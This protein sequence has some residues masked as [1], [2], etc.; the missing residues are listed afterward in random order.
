MS[1]E[2][3]V[4]AT[5]EQVA[6]VLEQ[7]VDLPWPD[8]DWVEW[9]LDGLEGQSSWLT[10]VLPLASGAEEAAVSALVVPL[11]ELAER[12]WG[13]ARRFDASR[14]TDDAST[15]PASY[16]RRS[17]LA[18]MV[19][20]LGASEARWWTYV[21][22]ALV[23][24]DSSG[25][26]PRR[27]NKLAVL[28]LPTPWLLPSGREEAALRSPLVDDLLSGDRE[29]V[30]GAVWAILATRDPETLRPVLTALPAIERATTDLD[31]G[32]AL[33][34]NAAHLA[35][36]LARVEL[37]GTMTCLCTAY[38]GHQFYDPATEER[39]G[40][41]R[42]EGTVPNERQWEPDRI[43]A[44]TACGRHYQVEH[45]EYHYPWWAWRALP[46]DGSRVR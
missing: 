28:V 6:R 20:S 37:V 19:R 8:D 43:C 25:Q 24:V 16:D 11:V 9:E 26:V 46:E 41:V 35:H 4:A 34:A 40:H 21:G 36:A 18:G 12:R 45:G 39:R 32:G 5:A 15:D 22:H 23:L 7:V 17:A 38:P 27:D 2:T 10:H 3:I 31:L 13:R 29:R 33:A 1:D 42:I 14:Y 30:L 44:C